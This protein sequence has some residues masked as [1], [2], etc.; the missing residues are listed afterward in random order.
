MTLPELLD[1]L[2]KKFPHVRFNSKYHLPQETVVVEVTT[3]LFYATDSRMGP[4]MVE[5]AKQRLEPLAAALEQAGQ[6][7]LARDRGEL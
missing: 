5:L 2:R 1:D 7:A 4:V 6:D 3:S